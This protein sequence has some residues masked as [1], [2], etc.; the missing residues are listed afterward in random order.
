MSCDYEVMS[1]V[2]G[3]KHWISAEYPEG[4]DESLNAPT[5]TPAA[6]SPSPEGYSGA[7]SQALLERLVAEDGVS[8]REQPPYTTTLD[9][10]SQSE[11]P[12]SVG[13]RRIRSPPTLQSLDIH[14]G[15]L[16]LPPSPTTP[17]P[18]TSGSS[19]DD[20]R[21]PPFYRTA[22]DFQQMA[23]QGEEARS[24]NAILFARR[25]AAVTGPSPPQPGLQGQI[26][27]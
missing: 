25:K 15:S 5:N 9:P 26:R 16:P 24:A 11:R 7:V 4:N 1:S 23:V 21:I 20:H 10:E 27:P 18:A 12:S 14:P 2:K 3:A 8:P 13:I 22:N 17:I 6:Q 19:D